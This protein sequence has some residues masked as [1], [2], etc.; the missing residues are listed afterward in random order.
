MTSILDHQ[1]PKLRPFPI[2][3]GVSWVQIY[4]P[5]SSKRP[6]PL[7]FFRTKMP[8]TGVFSQSRR[9]CCEARSLVRSVRSLVLWSVIRPVLGRRVLRTAPPST[10]FLVSTPE[11]SSFSRFEDVRRPLPGV[12]PGTPQGETVAE[13]ASGQLPSKT[14]LWPPTWAAATLRTCQAGPETTQSDPVSSPPGLEA[15]AWKTCE[16]TAFCSGVALPQ[17]EPG[18]GHPWLP[19]ATFQATFEATL[20]IL[21]R[22]GSLPSGARLRAELDG[23][24]LWWDRGTSP[25]W[26]PWTPNPLRRPFISFFIGLRICPPPPAATSSSNQQQE[27]AAGISS[28]NQQQRAAAIAAIAVAATSSKQQATSST[29]ASSTGRS[30]QYSKQQAASSKQ[31]QAA[32]SSNKQQ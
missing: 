27:P 21:A 1:T 19:K 5:G 13:L 26:E 8:W 2:K 3:T 6:K 14:C 11:F 12:A 22:R 23:G 30:R 16:W 31:Q 32:A 29:A 20:G 9:F 28:S 24:R 25:F 17:S 4:T 18:A 10:A 7:S 15:C